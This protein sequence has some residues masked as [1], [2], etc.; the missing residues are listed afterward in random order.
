MALLC[1]PFLVSVSSFDAMAMD[2][3]YLR[4]IRDGG[5]GHPLPSC[6]STHQLGEDVAFVSFD[7][8]TLGSL[9][10]R[11]VRHEGVGFPLLPCRWT[12]HPTPACHLTR[13][14]W[15]PFAL[16]SAFVLLDRAVMA[17]PSPPCRRGNL[18]LGVRHGYPNP[19][20]GWRFVLPL[21]RCRR[22]P[23]QHW[24][25]CCPRTPPSWRSRSWQ[26]WSWPVF[27]LSCGF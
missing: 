5:M 26:P 18:C 25:R 6:Y 21:G 14:R 7:T 2:T 9:R 17:F 22:D 11:V 1:Y 4:V 12:W 15:A 19:I 20:V 3:L 10:L 23:T 27:S 13:R 16:P 24:A 8:E